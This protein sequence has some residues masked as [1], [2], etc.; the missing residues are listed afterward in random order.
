MRRSEVI[1]S[2]NGSRVMF[3]LLATGRGGDEDG[4]F[5][6]AGQYLSWN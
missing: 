5:A 6:S 4:F 3:V 1:G 2:W